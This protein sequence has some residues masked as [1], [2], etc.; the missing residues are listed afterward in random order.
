MIWNLIPRPLSV[1][2]N[3]EFFH[4]TSRSRIIPQSAAARVPAALLAEYLAPATGYAPG[5]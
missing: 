5:M 1:S 3:G 2:E 4:L